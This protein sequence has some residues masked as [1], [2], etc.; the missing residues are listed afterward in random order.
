MIFPQVNRV[1]FSF[2]S[3]PEKFKV[4]STTNFAAD[5]HRRELLGVEDE[6]SQLALVRNAFAWPANVAKLFK[7]QQLTL[8]F[9]TKRLAEPSITLATACFMLVSLKMHEEPSCALRM[10]QSSPSIA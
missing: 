1:D 8:R 5:H 10:L 2:D 3:R 7:L 6:R 4:S 9:L